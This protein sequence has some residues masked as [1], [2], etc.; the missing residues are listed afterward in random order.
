V[1]RWL[2]GARFLGSAG[3]L[4]EERIRAVKTGACPHTAIRDDIAM[5]LMAVEHIEGDFAPVDLLVVNK[6]DLAAYVDQMI[7]DATKARSGGPVLGLTSCAP[8][9]GG[10]AP[11]TWPV[12]TSPPIPDRWH[13]TSTRPATAKSC[14]TATNTERRRQSRH[15]SDVRRLPR[16]VVS[17]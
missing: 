16:L 8:G 12:G 6:I 10:C 11:S 1:L 15:S 9:S 7:A 13:R 4:P 2:E 17:R 3:V 14:S 5:N